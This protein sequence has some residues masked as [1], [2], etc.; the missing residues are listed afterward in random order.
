MDD[1]PIEECDAEI[2]DDGRREGRPPVA[3]AWS[4]RGRATTRPQ[5]LRASRCTDGCTGGAA[6]RRK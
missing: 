3:V 2:R 5:L 4:Q 6:G 1:D